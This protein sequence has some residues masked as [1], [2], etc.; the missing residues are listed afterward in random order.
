MLN[1]H[2]AQRKYAIAHSLMKTNYYMC[3]R[4]SDN[5]RACDICFSDGAL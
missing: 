2:I 5:T 4:L 3:I 1:A